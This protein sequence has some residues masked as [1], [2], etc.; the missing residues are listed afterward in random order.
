MNVPPARLTAFHDAI[1]AVCP[2]V[3]VGADGS[4][5]FDPANPPT[6]AQQTAA[7]QVVQTWAVAP[8]YAECY[9]WQLQAVM[10]A[11][12]WTAVTNAV[13]AMSSPAVSAFFSH[14]GQLIPSSSTT[15]QALATAIGLT[16][17]QL[18]ALMQQAAQVSIP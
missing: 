1:A 15:L 17:A 4:L 13:A 16:Q 9:L 7:E 10:S 3:G 5:Q 2:I 14:P 6:Q 8:A 18:I 11:D 12:Q